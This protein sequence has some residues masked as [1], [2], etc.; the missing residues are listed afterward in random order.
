MSATMKYNLKQ[1][2]DISNSG[3]QFEIPNDTC[4]II[5][6][7]CSK[8]G[9]AGIKSNVFIK[10]TT[11]PNSVFANSNSEFSDFTQTKNKKKRGNRRME[12]SSEEWESIRTFETTKIE[13]KNGIDKEIDQVRLY[14]NKITDKTFLDMRTKINDKIN[15]ICQENYCEEDIRKLANILYDISSANKFYSKIFADLFSE[16]ATSHVWLKSIFDEKFAS[17]MENYNNIQYIDADTDYDGFCDMNKNNEKRRSIT[18]FYLNLSRNNFIQKSELIK[19]LKEILTTIVNMIEVENKKNE[20]DE[21]TEIVAI[22]FDKDMIEEV[23][24]EA[25]DEEIYYVLDESIINTVESLANKKSKDYNSLSNK[26]IF[27][28]MD[29]VEM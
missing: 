7:L 28:Y 21:L 24:D 18:T 26:S 20:V 29:M 1:I 6:Y 2:T 3:F 11:K 14:L 12:V 4:E 27:K 22:L 23:Y 9:S 19:I 10:S 25:D 5:N 8:V 13:Q 15:S 16:L 17:I